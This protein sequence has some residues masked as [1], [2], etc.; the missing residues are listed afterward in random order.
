MPFR[1][2][3]LIAYI[4]VSSVLIH[5]PNDWLMLFDREMAELKF[6]CGESRVLCHYFLIM[7]VIDTYLKYPMTLFIHSVFEVVNA[8]L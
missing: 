5:V 8:G 1:V 6:P 3:R 4:K 2:I 7:T